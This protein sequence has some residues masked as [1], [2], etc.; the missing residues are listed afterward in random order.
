M[1]KSTAAA[2][3][4]SNEP[5]PNRDGVQLTSTKDLELGRETI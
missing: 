1:T 3:L 2:F 4:A 5:S